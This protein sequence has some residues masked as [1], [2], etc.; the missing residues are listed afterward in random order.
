M[1]GDIL[2]FTFTPDTSDQNFSGVQSG[3]AMKYK[4]MAADNRR[5]TQERL[6]ERGLMRRLRLAVNV[7][8]I[9]GNS[10]VNYDAIND[11]EILFTPNIPQN[12]NELIANVKSL[13]G[14]VSD[15]TLLE[16]LKQFT[17]VDADEEL[18]RLEKQKADNQLMFNGQTNDYPNPDQE[19]VIE[20]GD[21]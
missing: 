21:E 7:W 8:R 5:V 6:F 9:K 14:I 12:V 15:E 18:K 20:D 19:G 13:Y 16:L 1:V 10:S 4:L 2:R 17:G 3:E 11:T